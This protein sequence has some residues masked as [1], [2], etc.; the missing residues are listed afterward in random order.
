MCTGISNPGHFA[1]T[2]VLGFE[3]GKPRFAFWVYV[4]TVK[5]KV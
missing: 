4:L 2:W 3:N 5:E 1:Q